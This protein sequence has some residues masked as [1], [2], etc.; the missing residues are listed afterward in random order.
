MLIQLS[1]YTLYLIFVGI[2]LY[3]CHLIVTSEKRKRTAQTD[4]FNRDT[5]HHSPQQ[6]I[7]QITRHGEG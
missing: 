5:P 1:I 4:E 6:R 2:I 7:I 3:S